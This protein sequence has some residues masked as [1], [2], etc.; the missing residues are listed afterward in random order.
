MLSFKGIKESW[1][2][3]QGGKK[4]GVG[5]EGGVGVKHGN[6]GSEFSCESQ[7]G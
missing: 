3:G 6:P 2:A 1:G 4:Q 7:T 5:A